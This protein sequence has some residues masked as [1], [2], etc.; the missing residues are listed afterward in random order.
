[1]CHG[2]SLQSTHSA[3]HLDMCTI[4]PQCRRIYSWHPVTQ[5]KRH[6]SN[7]FCAQGHTPLVY[8]WFQPW[9]WWKWHGNPDLPC[10]GS[11]PSIAMGLWRTCQ[12]WSGRGVSSL[13]GSPQL[14]LGGVQWIN[15]HIYFNSCVTKIFEKI[16]FSLLVADKGREL[17]K[18]FQELRN[19]QDRGLKTCC[20]RTY[21][22]L[23]LWKGHISSRECR[24]WFF[25]QLLFFALINAA[26]VSLL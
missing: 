3:F 1:M 12:P 15:A 5:P 7:A 23:E 21:V 24:V 6:C 26:S 11:F 25:M 2:W 16:M 9:L 19:I 20:Y 8:L 22:L 10:A 17:L 18:V 4:C 14:I 13:W